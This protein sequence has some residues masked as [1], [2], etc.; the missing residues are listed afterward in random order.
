MPAI[1]SDLIEKL[2]TKLGVSKRR[3]YARIQTIVRRQFLERDLAALVLANEVGI[4]IHRYSSPGQ[5]AALRTGAPPEQKSGDFPS[6]TDTAAPRK[7]KRPNVSG[8]HN[9]RSS[10]FVVHGRDEK[11]RKSMFDFLRALE[12]KPLEWEKAILLAKGANPHIEDVIDTAMSRVQA[13]VVIFSPD[14]D[15][16]L[17]SHFC[18]REDRRSEGRLQGQPRPNV[19]FEAGVALGRHPEK[20]L[21]IQIGKV[22]SFTDIAGKHLVKLNNDPAKRQDFAN[23]LRKL[24]CSVSTQGTDWLKAG[25]FS[26]DI[27]LS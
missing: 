8:K 21:L 18:S 9:D 25:D 23:R 12:L 19:I 11:L 2:E 5:R 10:V 13:V 1:N 26:P 15:V 24:K 20:T 14:D 7:S 16:K 4:G 3:I 27:G 22:K 17:K 6:V